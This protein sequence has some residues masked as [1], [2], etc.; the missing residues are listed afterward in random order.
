MQILIILLD[1]NI[2]L[3]SFIFKTSYIKEMVL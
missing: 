2:R 1:N 3:I